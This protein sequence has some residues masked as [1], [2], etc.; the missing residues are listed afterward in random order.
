MKTPLP[1]LALIALAFCI[2]AQTPVVIRPPASSATV[3]SPLT[4]STSQSNQ[5][6]LA[7]INATISQRRF[8]QQVLTLQTTPAVNI[9]Q[10]T[11]GVVILKK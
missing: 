7:H 4:N 11:Q 1:I 5:A 3:I 9:T 8:E 2:R 6:L 10:P